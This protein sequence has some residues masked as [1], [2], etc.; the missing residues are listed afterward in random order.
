MA[1]KP[2]LLHTI[3]NLSDA[4]DV[5]GQSNDSLQS[6]L[7]LFDFMPNTYFYIKD[8]NRRFL[9]MNEP[10]RQHVGA[11]S[12]AECLGKE[13]ADFFSPDLV[14]LY[15]REDDEVF[16]SRCPILN[17][18]WIVPERKGRSKWFLSSKIPMLGRGNEVVALTG[19]MQNLAHEFE[20]AHPLGEMQAVVDHV[21]EHYHERISMETLAS[22]AFLSVRQFERRFRSLFHSSPGEFILKVRIDAAT[23]LLMESDLSITQIAI[24]CGFYDNSH[25]TRLF[26]KKMGDSPIQFRKKLLDV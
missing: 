6:V 25:F 15:H 21:I 12:L 7:R 14:F 11:S 5:I 16:A 13:D 4:L 8:K 1:V 10:L 9:W 17:R 23:R 2:Y 26:K 3:M 20:I 18:P 22:L 19:I 24:L